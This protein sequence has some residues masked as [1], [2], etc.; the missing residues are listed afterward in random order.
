MIQEPLRMLF[1]TKGR[2]NRL[3]YFI[4]FVV[5]SSILAL[6]FIALPYII[7]TYDGIIKDVLIAVAIVVFVVCFISEICIS[8]RRLH[9]LN[10][11]G[12]H[13]LK[14]L[15]P[16]YNFYFNLLLF[17]YE[18]TP[19]PNNYGD[20]PL[21]NRG[22]SLYT[23]SAAQ[24][25]KSKAPAFLLLF[26]VLL[27]AFLLYKDLSKTS[28][29]E[30]YD[31]TENY[32][33]DSIEVI[34]SKSGN[35]KKYSTQSKIRFFEG[36]SG[37]IISLDTTIAVRNFKEKLR[38]FGFKELSNSHTFLNRSETIKNLG[39]KNYVT[40]DDTINI[41]IGINNAAMIYFI[42]HLKENLINNDV[43]LSIQIN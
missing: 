39:Y 27:V 36:Y 14:M 41:Q 12:F 22:V 5:T 38:E 16:F 30:E 9:D 40:I 37:F 25:E 23:K 28:V 13:Y 35:N 34:F 43:D 2:V 17:L 21:G 33:K 20:D 26:I 8:I 10:L 3:P 4:H 7:S 29:N 1:H 31:V 19:G 6:S 11:S 18:G 32:L 15:I 42:K 24:E